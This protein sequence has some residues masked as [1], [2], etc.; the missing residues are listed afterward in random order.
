[1]LPIIA[2]DSSALAGAVW[3]SADRGKAWLD[4]MLKNVTPAAASCDTPL[5]KNIALGRKYGI[6]GT[7]TLIFADGQRLSGWM[8]ATRLSQLLDE[9]G[10]R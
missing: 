10:A 1:L 5:E 4:L 9:A 3:C 2:A 7:P 8:P 6:K